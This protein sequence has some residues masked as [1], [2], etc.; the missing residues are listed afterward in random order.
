MGGHG[1]NLLAWDKA[2]GEEIGKL[3]LRSAEISGRVSGAPM[4]YMHEGKQY[5][6]L[7]MTGRDSKA[8]LVGIALP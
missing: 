3:G 6:A 5:I 4:T 2:T 7:A 8:W 1:S